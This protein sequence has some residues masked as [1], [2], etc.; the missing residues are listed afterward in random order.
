MAY[1]VA[2]DLCENQNQPFLTR[3]A[4]LLPDVPVDAKAATATTTAAAAAPN[5]TASS[6]TATSS[7][8]SS[9][10]AMDTSEKP[11]DAAK[12]E[13]TEK[14]KE[15]EKEA[16][17]YPRRLKNVKSILAGDTS[18]ALHLQFLYGQNRID[19]NILKQIKVWRQQKGTNGVTYKC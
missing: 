11:A 5:T 1:Q 8:S 6:T 15:A 19:Q 14:E 3:V 17:T 18:M 7:S 16:D 4:K 2:F 10:S 9:S 13:K 12:N